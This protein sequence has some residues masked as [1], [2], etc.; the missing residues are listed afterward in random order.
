MGGDFNCVIKTIIDKVGG[1]S[2]NR[3]YGWKEP[4]FVT[5]GNRLKY[6]YRHKFPNQLTVSWS[7]GQIGCLLDRFFIPNNL[8]NYIEEVSLVSSSFLGHDLL[9]LKLSELPNCVKMGKVYWKFNNSLLND[10]ELEQK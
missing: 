3:T 4:E 9:K 5:K 7:D 6:V 10:F 8:T 2:D 1:N